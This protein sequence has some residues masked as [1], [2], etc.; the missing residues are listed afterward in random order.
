MAGPGDTPAQVQGSLHL[1]RAEAS[2]GETVGVYWDF[3]DS[4]YQANNRDGIGIFEIEIGKRPAVVLPKAF[5]V[6]SPVKGKWTPG[7]TWIGKREATAGRCSDTSNGN[8]C[9]TYSRV[10]RISVYVSRQEEERERERSE[11]EREC[12]RKQ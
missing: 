12:P 10:S 4:G 6:L 3:S 11:G 7:T 2:V 5:E 1:D 8:S 9:R